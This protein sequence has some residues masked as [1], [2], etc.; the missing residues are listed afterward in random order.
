MFTEKPGVRAL[1]AADA[2]ALKRA[3]NGELFAHLYPHLFAVVAYR[4]AHRLGK[5]G[6]P[7]IAHLVSVIAQTLTGAEIG[8]TAEIGPGLVLDHPLGVILADGCAAGRNLRVGAAVILGYISGDPESD[9]SQGC[10]TIGD[11]VEI[12]ARATVAGPVFVG[13]GV[14]VGAHA[15]VLED[16]PAGAVARGVPAR[17]YIEGRQVP[18]RHP[19][20]RAAAA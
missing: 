8:W 1:I 11:N 16:V 9:P 12:W 5:G 15:L 6:F 18:R 2:A 17:S 7:R 3:R 10:P 4:V 20:P 14:R 13:D 19:I